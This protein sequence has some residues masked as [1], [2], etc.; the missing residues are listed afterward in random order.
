MIGKHLKGYKRRY[1]ACRKAEP[2]KARIKK[3][4]DWRKRWMP[5]IKYD[6]DFDGSFLLELIV[7]KLH[8]MLDFYEHGEYCHQ[9]DE[10][11]LQ[12][13]EELK[14][15]C[16]LGDL[17]VA[18]AF[19]DP[20]LQIMSEHHRMWTTP[21][22]NGMAK[23]NMEWDD[24]ANEVLYN[25]ASK[26]CEELRERTIREFFDYVCEHFRNWWD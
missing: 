12:I 13:V 20:A 5:F 3:N 18:D 16:R 7:H 8:I 1:L 2:R 10:S 22:E 6:H 15:A 14:E 9:V 24:P 23:I 26:S 21:A 19:D 17:L 4:D 11:R 25:K